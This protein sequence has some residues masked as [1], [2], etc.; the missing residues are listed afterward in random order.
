MKTDNNIVCLKWTLLMS[1]ALE[2]S[3]LSCCCYL[4]SNARI[5]YTFLEFLLVF[6]FINTS[7]H[8]ICYHTYMCI[9]CCKNTFTFN[10][11]N[12]KDAEVCNLVASFRASYNNVISV[13]IQSVMMIMYIFLLL[14]F[15]IYLVDS[16]RFVN[17]SFHMFF[18]YHVIVSQT[19]YMVWDFLL[20]V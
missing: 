19:F 2:V 17:L 5:L 8:C 9:S 13:K 18:C 7:M 20:A 11:L 3:I 16:T 12:M 14:Y 4:I 1:T 6:L 15:F 10:W